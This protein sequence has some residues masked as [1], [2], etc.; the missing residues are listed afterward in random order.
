[1]RVDQEDDHATQAGKAVDAASI[2]AVSRL[3]AGLTGGTRGAQS[4]R[5]QGNRELVTRLLDCLYQETGKMG[6]E[7][8]PSHASTP[9]HYAETIDASTLAYL[10]A[11]CE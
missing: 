5:N 7:V 11:W 3:S 10:S 1:M 9:L 6:K 2:P 4:D 8:R